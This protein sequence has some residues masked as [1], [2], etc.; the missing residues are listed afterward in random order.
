MGTFRFLPSTT[1]ARLALAGAITLMYIIGSTVYMRYGSSAFPALETRP[2][3]LGHTETVLSTAGTEQGSLPGVETSRV[4]LVSSFFPLNT[5]KIPQKDYDMW[6]HNYLGTV[7]TDIYF[8]TTPDQ[9]ERVK[10]FRPE[11]MPMTVDT[12]FASIF[13]VPP[14]KDKVEAYSRNRKKDRAR[15]RHSIES[16]AVLNSKPFFLTNAV[17][18]SEAK[19]LNYTYAFWND[20]MSFHHEHEFR[21]WPSTHRL[22]ELWA[23]G[24]N[25]TGTDSTD[26]LFIPT[27]DLPHKTMYLWYE[28][29][30]PI[31]HKFN[32]GKS[33]MTQEYI[34]SCR[35]GIY[36]SSRYLFLPLSPR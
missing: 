19:G 1:R 17:K 30:G 20:A 28:G 34:D 31:E 26:L 15:P 32:E 27:W 16:Y 5:S 6:L 7:E 22:D 24:S 21:Q 10:S 8:Y 33:T 13:D 9:A 23:A 25:I 12:T 4:L 14:L 3:D 2:D 11:G 29:E 35:K 36:S 18:A